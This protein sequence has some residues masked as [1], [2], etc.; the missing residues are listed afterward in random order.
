MIPSEYSVILKHSFQCLVVYSHVIFVCF[1]LLKSFD[2]LFYSCL[3]CECYASM[4]SGCFCITLVSVLL[5]LNHMLNKKNSQPNIFSWGQLWIWTR[6][7]IKTENLS[8]EQRNRDAF[9][10]GNIVDAP[11]YSKLTYLRFVLLMMVHKRLF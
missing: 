1:S 2:F 7:C 9:R 8:E 3:P 6:V 10:Y 5:P 4:S 11:C